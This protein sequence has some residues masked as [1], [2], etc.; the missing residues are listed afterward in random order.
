MRLVYADG[1]PVPT[2]QERIDKALA[3]A[4]VFVATY[5]VYRSVRTLNTAWQAVK[6]KK[7]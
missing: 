4:G 7:S 3:Y 5:G 6:E 2:R 1:T